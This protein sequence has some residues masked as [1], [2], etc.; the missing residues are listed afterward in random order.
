MILFHIQSSG[1]PIYQQ[2]VQQVRDGIAFGKLVPGQKMPSLR[3][4][5]EFLVINYLTVKQA[6]D[7][8][9]QEGLIETKRGKGT[10]VCGKSSS[11]LK[12]SS[13][14]ALRQEMSQLMT[15]ARLNGMVLEQFKSMANEVWDDLK[16]QREGDDQ[17]ERDS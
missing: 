9:E 3:Q 13:R 14:Q 17:K 8:L 16:S 2:L 5:A 12:Q 7:I 6:Y 1:I 11:K 4:V 10:Y 15:R